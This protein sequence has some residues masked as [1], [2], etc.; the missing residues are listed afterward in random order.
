MENQSTDQTFNQ[1][2]NLTNLSDW[3]TMSVCLSF[4]QSVW[5]SILLYVHASIHLSGPTSIPL[6]IQPPDKVLA[7]KKCPCGIFAEQDYI[8]DV[9]RMSNCL[10][11]AKIWIYISSKIFFYKLGKRVGISTSTIID[12]HSEA[13]FGICILHDSRMN[14]I[15]PY[16]TYLCNT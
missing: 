11:K 2:V 15:D 16:L 9:E 3:H 1:L 8:A 5:P 14:K 12:N 10:Q 4:G 7:V 6:S 13:G